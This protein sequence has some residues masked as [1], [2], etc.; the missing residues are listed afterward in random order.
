M[1]S[2]EVRQLSPRAPFSRQSSRWSR[3]CRDAVPGLAKRA[4]SRP[5]TRPRGSKFWVF[6]KLCKRLHDSVLDGLNEEIRVR[7][8][9]AWSSGVDTHALA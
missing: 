9:A 3:G 2:A 8:L 4:F 1:C 7:S 5:K 6:R